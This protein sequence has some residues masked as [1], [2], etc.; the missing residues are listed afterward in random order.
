MAG[1]DEEEVR[2]RV[3]FFAVLSFSSLPPFAALL[4][5]PQV[6]GWMMY[7]TIW[8]ITSKEVFAGPTWLFNTPWEV[9]KNIARRDPRVQE[10][11]S[12]SLWTACAVQ[13]LRIEALLTRV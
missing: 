3:S 8:R 7:D 2:S 5:L 13:K 11:N 1:W 6:L 4:D 10:A 9:W 12:F